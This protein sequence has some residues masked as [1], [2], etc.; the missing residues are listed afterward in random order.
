MTLTLLSKQ[1]PSQLFVDGF[2]QYLTQ[3]ATCSNCQ[4]NGQIHAIFEVSGD[5][6]FT[7]KQGSIQGLTQIAT[8]DG[9]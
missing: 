4:N 3:T 9:T 1:G 6:T 7:L 8:V 5:A 2:D